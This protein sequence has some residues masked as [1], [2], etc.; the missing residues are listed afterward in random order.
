MPIHAIKNYIY[1]HL[2]KA[3]NGIG[4]ETEFR[5]VKNNI[6]EKYKNLNLVFTKN[7]GKYSGKDIIKYPFKII[8][9]VSSTDNDKMNVS[10]SFENNLKELNNII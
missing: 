10:K 3:K 2:E 7:N 1:Y 6:N 4:R 9:Y 5:I 8:H